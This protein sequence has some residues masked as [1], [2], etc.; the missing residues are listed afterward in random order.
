MINRPSA[1]AGFCI[2][3]SFDW[4]SLQRSSFFPEIL[5]ECRAQ[6]TF[7]KGRNDNHN[8]FPLT[9]RALSHSNC[10][11]DGRS[12]GDPAKN[13]LFRRHQTGHGH[14]VFAGNLYHFIQQG[15]IGI[16]GDESGSNALDF[17]RTRFASTQDGGF[18]RFDGHNAQILVKWLQILPATREGSTSA[19]TTHED[20][21]L[22]ASVLPDFRSRR[23]LVDFGIVWVVELLEQVA[24][25]AQ[26][27]DE[28][29][30]LCNGW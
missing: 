8:A 4:R 25:R 1:S 10:R 26:L 22:V 16:A 7:S 23:L 3:L 15:G 2:Y 13:A 5:K 19:Y 24:V 17:V 18:D 21:D 12:G 29:L 11:Q 9:L 14:G 30:G 6:V 27:A 20:I 28:F